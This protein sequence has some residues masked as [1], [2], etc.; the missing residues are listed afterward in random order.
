MQKTI[1]T[2]AVTGGDDVAHKYQQL[3]VTPAQIA[4][5]A[6]GA[7]KAGAAI[8]HIHVR[9]PATGKPSMELNLYREVFLAFAIRHFKIRYKQAAI[10][11]GWSLVQP[12]FAAILFAI[13]L[14]RFAHLS[15]EG[16]PYFLFALAGL[17]P[18]TFFSTAL[19]SF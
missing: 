17:V 2:C 11:V 13:F 19:S 8:A 6:I 12:V 4:E 3:P 1:I 15:G 10:G 16:R 7:A 18:W 5:A 14:G 9:D